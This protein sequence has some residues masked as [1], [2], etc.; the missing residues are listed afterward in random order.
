MCRGCRDDGHSLAVRLLS[1]VWVG[2]HARQLLHHVGVPSVTCEQQPEVPPGRSST[3]AE[4]G[5]LLPPELPE[6]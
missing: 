3:V 1:L 6:I 4:Q 2:H 5:L